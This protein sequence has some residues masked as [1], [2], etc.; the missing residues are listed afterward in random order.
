MLEYTQVGDERIVYKKKKQNQ[1][2][3]MGWFTV[4]CAH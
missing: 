3:S 1:T 4:G 2:S